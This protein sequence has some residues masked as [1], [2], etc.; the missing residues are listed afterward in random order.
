MFKTATVLVKRGHNTQ[1]LQLRNSKFQKKRQKNNLNAKRIVLT[2]CFISGLAT[3]KD[4]PFLQIRNQ[5]VSVD[6]LQELFFHDSVQIRVTLWNKKNPSSF[7][8]GS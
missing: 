2:A 1:R 5:W 7:L 3:L 8:V 6:T 4:I